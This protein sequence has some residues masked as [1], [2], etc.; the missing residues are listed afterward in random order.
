MLVCS[1][2]AGFTGLVA[3]EHLLRPDLPPARRFFSEYGRGRTRSVRA[4]ALACWAV[5]GGGCAAV[6]DVALTIVPV[7]AA[8]RIDAPDAGQRGFAL[9]GRACRR[10]FAMHLPEA[11]AR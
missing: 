3:L 4:A 8:L 10:A 9:P 1:G 5:A 11:G 2:V 6:A 7:L